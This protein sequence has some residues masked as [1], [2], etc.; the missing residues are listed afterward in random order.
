MER[1]IPLP[2]PEATGK[3]GRPEKDS[4]AMLNGMM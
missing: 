2:P 3:K 1:I 4:Q